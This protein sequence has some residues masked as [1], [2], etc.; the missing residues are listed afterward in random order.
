MNHHNFS[1]RWWGRGYNMVH[2]YV[3]VRV[4]MV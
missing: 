3:S 4:V 2:M 1:H